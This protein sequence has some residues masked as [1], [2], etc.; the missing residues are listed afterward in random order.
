MTDREFDRIKTLIAELR[1]WVDEFSQEEMDELN[2]LLQAEGYRADWSGFLE[3]VD[4]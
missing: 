4:E 3:K 2:S 1:W